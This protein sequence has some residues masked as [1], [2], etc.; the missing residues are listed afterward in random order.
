MIAFRVDSNEII[1]TGHFMRCKVI[2]TELQS[3][4]KQVLFICADETGYDL[5]LH[6]GFPALVL[7]S[8]WNYLDG[9]TEQLIEIIRTYP[10]EKLII[11][12]YQVTYE[13]LN[14]LNKVVP[15][16][17]IDDLNAFTYPVSILVN[18]NM[19]AHDMQYVEK[20]HNTPTKQLL[21]LDYL[22]LRPEFQSLVREDRSDVSNI[23]ISTGGS[24]PLQI[25]EQLVFFLNSQEDLQS[26]MLHVVLG[27]FSSF[28][29][30]N[31]SHFSNIRLHRNVEKMADLMLLCDIAITA[32]GSTMYELCACGLPAVSFSFADNQLP[33]VLSMDRNGLIPYA[34]DVRDDTKASMSGIVKLARELI[35]DHNKR[36]VIR[37]AMQSLI[38]GLGGKRLVEAITSVS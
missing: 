16:I 20:Y 35:A 30:Q 19:Y 11:D 7:H 13:Y 5:A 29:S 23:L 2:A 1:A 28:S 6:H 38:D 15:V 3:L 33:G 22:P 4:G 27:Q 37:D 25:A 31:I 17:Y 34:G 21:G 8:L 9:E 14:A 24:D 18:Y 32:G 36:I 10:I 26:I 12:S